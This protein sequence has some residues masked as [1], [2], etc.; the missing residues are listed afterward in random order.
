[1]AWASGRAAVAAVLVWAGWAAGAGAAAPIVFSCEGETL[2]KTLQEYHAGVPGTVRTVQKVIESG[3]KALT[4][5]PVSVVRKDATPPS[6]DKHDYMSLSPYW[7]ADPAKA[8]GL[9][10]IRRDGEFNP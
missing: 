6:G 9:P 7:W 8:D 4:F 2:E 3:E 5:E 1:M 10:Y